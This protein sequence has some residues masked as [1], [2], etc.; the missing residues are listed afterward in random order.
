MQTI[1][2]V[3]L[4]ETCRPSSPSSSLALARQD[5]WGGFTHPI[6]AWTFSLRFKLPFLH[7]EHNQRGFVFVW[8]DHLTSHEKNEHAAEGNLN[9]KGSRNFP[10]MAS[11]KK[12]CSWHHAPYTTNT[13]KRDLISLVKQIHRNRNSWRGKYGPS[14]T[15]PPDLE[16][17]RELIAV[18]GRNLAK[19]RWLLITILYTTSPQGAKERTSY[20]VN[21]HAGYSH[22]IWSVEL[23]SNFSRQCNTRDVLSRVNWR[24]FFSVIFTTGWS[25]EL[26]A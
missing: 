6:L 24:P 7:V 15:Q 25:R 26:L 18:P 11:G 4:S 5:G 16:T 21:L 23:S 22:T 14:R 9:D 17:P 1:T 19:R 3:M 2:E 20:F 12:L 8:R 13:M 10:T